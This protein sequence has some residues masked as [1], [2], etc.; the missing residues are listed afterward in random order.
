[1][2]QESAGAIVEYLMVSAN[3]NT[4]LPSLI[5]ADSQIV[6]FHTQHGNDRKWPCRRHTGCRMVHSRGSLVEVVFRAV[7]Y[8]VPYISFDR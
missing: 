6:D 7:L 5:S 2:S 3:L 8:L 1:M 4:F